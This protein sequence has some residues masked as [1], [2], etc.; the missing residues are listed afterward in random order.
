MMLIVPTQPVPSQSLQVQLNGQNCTLNIY[1]KQGLY[2]D[3]LVN[4]VLVVAG[5]IGENLNLI[6]RSAYLGF[7]GDLVW[8]DNEAP[9]PTQGIDPVYTGLGTRFSLAY[10]FPG[11]I[12]AT[13]G[14]GVS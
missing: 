10:L 8:I 4:N 5:V 13:A 9:T 1:T 3:V 11:E 14:I 2:T 7:I 12:P 6:I